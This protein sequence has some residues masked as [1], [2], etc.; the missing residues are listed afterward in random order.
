MPSRHLATGHL[1]SEGQLP[2][3]LVKRIVGAVLLLAGLALIGLGGWFANYLGSDG[4]ARFTVDP[5][6]ATPLVL[7]PRILNRTDQPVRIEITPATASTAVVAVGTP[8]DALSV[9]EGKALDAV[10]A[11]ELPAKTATVTRRPGASGIDLTSV[12]VWRSTTT[13]TSTDTV[14]IRQ[15]TAPETVVIAPVGDGKLDAVTLTWTRSAWFKQAIAVVAAGVVVTLVGA[16]LL[17]RRRRRQPPGPTDDGRAGAEDAVE[18][19]A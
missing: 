5:V 19:S 11:V 14:T 9:I 16:W 2:V 8:A 1:A 17:L 12:N 18:V 4:A 13:I 6:G 3:H 15:D 10:T 7:E